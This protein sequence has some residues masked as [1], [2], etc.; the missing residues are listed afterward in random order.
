MDDPLTYDPL[1]LTYDPLNIQ[2]AFVTYDPLTYSGGFCHKR[3]MATSTGPPA[4]CNVDIQEG[5]KTNYEISSML[6]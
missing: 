5:A 3:S 1:G 4:P 2:E 6:K